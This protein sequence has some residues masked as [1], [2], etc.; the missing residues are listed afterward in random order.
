MVIR[1]ANVKLAK[2]T[3]HNLPV[4][5]GCSSGTK[6]ADIILGKQKKMADSY[7]GKCMMDNY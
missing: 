4:F 2:M 6:E 3:I 1:A 5:L 7:F